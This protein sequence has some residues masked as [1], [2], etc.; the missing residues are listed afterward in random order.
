MALI[1]V[2]ETSLETPCFKVQFKFVDQRP[3][4]SLIAL[5]W[6]DY[7]NR[8][9]KMVYRLARSKN[10]LRPTSDQCRDN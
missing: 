8:L 1:L 5:R 9:T 10:Q 3:K 4:T 2:Y 7:G 6:Y